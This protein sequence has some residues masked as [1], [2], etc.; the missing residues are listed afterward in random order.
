MVIAAYSPLMQSI[1]QM[2]GQQAA[3]K[4]RAIHQKGMRRYIID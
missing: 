3:T 2:Q 1:R 4:K